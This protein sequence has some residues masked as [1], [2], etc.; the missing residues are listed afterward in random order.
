MRFF[1]IETVYI[2][3]ILFLVG[4][5]LAQFTF[6]QTL[7]KKDTSDVRFLNSR[8][9]F[10]YKVEKGETLFSISQ[11]FNVP[12]EEITQFN[13]DLS[14]QGLKA[15][16]KLWIPAYSWLKKDSKAETTT[17][18]VDEVNPEKKLYRIAVVSALN[19]PKI[20]SPFASPSG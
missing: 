6:G 15:K 9:F 14:Q 8:K 18:E 4:L 17:E 16:T 19:L 5:L 20:K 12:Q 10:I 2:K 3:K 7:T 11:K 1:K 13:K